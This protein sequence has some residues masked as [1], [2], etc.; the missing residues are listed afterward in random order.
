MDGV[1]AQ[2]QEQGRR[3]R[4]RAQ[5]AAEEG[6]GSIPGPGNPPAAGFHHR[7]QQ[8][9]GQNRAAIE[10]AGNMPPR[11]ITVRA[12]AAKTPHRAIS[13]EVVRFIFNAS[14]SACHF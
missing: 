2:K 10:A 8:D 3:L 13:L 7:H 11:I 12:R 14:A 6:H 1:I 5:Q 4:V 9:A